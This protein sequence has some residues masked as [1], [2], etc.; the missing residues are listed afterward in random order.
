M[1]GV[2]LHIRGD[3]RLG[4]RT[5][6]PALDLTCPGGAW[7]VL[8]GPSGVGKSTLA[9][10]IAGLPGPAH[11]TGA[12]TASDG[13][14]P[15][16]RVTLMAQSDQL[17]PWASVLDNVT[18]GA[19]LRGQWPDHARAL[20]LLA[21][22]GLEGLAHR[23]PATLSGGQRQRVALAR[24]LIE[25]RAIV[26]MDEPFSAL[27][28]ATRAAMQDLAARLLQGRTVILITHDPLEAARLAHQARLM[29][30]DGLHPLPV[31]ATPPPRALSDPATLTA[32]A[33][34][35]ARLMQGAA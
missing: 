29:Q 34:L 19:R 25:A 3:L 22:V 10:L 13:A 27:D 4:G 20:D 35:Y 12:I 32:Q 17:L 9:R 2:A 14:P 26:V 7:T 11:L 16:G 6:C 28:A 30:G 18:L 33:D 23:R 1:S 8:L 31:P 5:L 21:R 24:S 15:E